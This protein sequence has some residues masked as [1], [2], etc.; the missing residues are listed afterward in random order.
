MAGRFMKFCNLFS[1]H[2]VVRGKDISEH[3]RSYLSG[4]LGT[5]RRKNIGR[6]EE[7]VSQS[8][9]QGM[10]QLMSDSPW[11]HQKLMRTLAEQADSLLGN[12]LDTALYLDE[13]SFVKKGDASVG[14]QRQYCGRLGKLENCQVGVFACL[15]RSHRTLLIDFRLFLPESWTKDPQR[16]AKAKV[17]L[18]ECKHRTKGQLALEMVMAARER[19]L[20]YQWIGGDEIYG[21]NAPLTDALDDMGEIFLMDVSANLKLWDQDPCP[22]K[23]QKKSGP[24]R[25]GSVSMPTQ[26]ASYLSVA[27]WAAQDF[28]KQSREVELRQT[29]KEVLRYRLWVKELWQWE[30]PD[31]K[32][33]PR[34]LVVRQEADGSFK[35]S[36]TNASAQTSWKRLGYMQAQRF[37]IE[38][39]FQDA[40]TELGMAQYEVRTWK[41]WHHHM[42]LVCLALLFV[43]KERLLAEDYIPL[44]SAR[45]VVEL[46]NYYLPRRSRDPDEILRAMHVRHAK[47][48][49]AIESFRKKIQKHRSQRV[50]K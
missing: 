40:K 49:K 42:A 21:N 1:A 50:T 12:H 16:C 38:R 17:P 22:Q 48:A 14:V 46:L 27:Q 36:L 35:Y 15:G 26:K 37:W 34:L 18:E 6:I 3:A 23:P 19:G 5:A 2:F 13:S 32:A 39:A 29:T 30:K 8:N 41:G 25:P 11:D 45:D 7:D 47:R 28:V 9:Y 20:S 44:L 24:G 33:R 4:L 31:P 43:L 10:Q